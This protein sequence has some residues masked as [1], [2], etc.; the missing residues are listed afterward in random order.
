MGVN[1]LLLIQ[2]DGI[3]FNFAQVQR[4]LPSGHEHTLL[5]FGYKSVTVNITLR[6]LKL[7]LREKYNIEIGEIKSAMAN[8]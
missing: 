5:D 1:N 8:N 4:L 6:A 3:I 7:I 2:I